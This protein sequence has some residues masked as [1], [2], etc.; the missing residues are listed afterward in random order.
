M[1]Y[2]K[3]PLHEALAARSAS[4]GTTYDIFFET[5]G[6]PDPTLF[7][8][9][10]AYLAPKGK[11]VSVGLDFSGRFMWNVFLKPSWLGGTDRTFKF[12]QSAHVIA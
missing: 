7:M 8:Q 2:Q 11:F 10:A 1:D 4:T 5:V 9:S 12:V 6:L 3:C